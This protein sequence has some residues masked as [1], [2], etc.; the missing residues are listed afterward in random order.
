LFFIG[1]LAF[2]GDRLEAPLPQGFF[3]LIHS[4]RP[5]ALLGDAAFG[6]GFA[7]M[8]FKVWSD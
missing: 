8:G 4:L 7:W 5:I 3:D 6:F 1:E 2:L